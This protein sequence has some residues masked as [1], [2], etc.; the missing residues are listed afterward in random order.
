MRAR[1]E[2]EAMR[3]GSEEEKWKLMLQA[4]WTLGIAVFCSLILVSLFS[5]AGIFVHFLLLLLPNGAGI[6]ILGSVFHAQ[7]KGLSA[8]WGLLGV[9]GP[10]G[11]LI[12]AVLPDRW[13]QALSQPREPLNE[14]SNYPRE[15]PPQIN[16]GMGSLYEPRDP[17]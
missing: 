10:I 5:S 12:I 8:A 14:L 15:F 4:R 9:F 7:S 11:P 3:F 16:N 6:W 17:G 1:W 13:A 2:E